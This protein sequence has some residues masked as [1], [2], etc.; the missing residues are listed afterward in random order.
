MAQGEGAGK[1]RRPF[2]EVKV[3]DGMYRR[4][5]QLH[6]CFKTRIWRQGWVLL[7]I[8][9]LVVFPSWLTHYVNNTFGAEPRISIPINANF[10]DNLSAPRPF[11]CP[12]KGMFAGMCGDRSIDRCIGMRIG[13]HIG[14][15][16]YRH[17]NRHLCR[18]LYEL[19]YR[20]AC[21]DPQQCAAVG[22][23]AQP[24]AAVDIKAQPCAAL[25]IKA[26][27]WVSSPWLGR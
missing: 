17:L 20:H 8:G 12:C 1:A 10:L 9:R 4:L 11:Q 3:K 6:R 5:P 14:I 7:M 25:D 21:L 19:V 22:T 15:Y 16:L 18:H 2:Y 26:Q 27:P 24:C 23:K 13:M